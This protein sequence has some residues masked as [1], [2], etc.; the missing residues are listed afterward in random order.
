MVQVYKQRAVNLCFVPHS[1]PPSLPLFFSQA[2]RPRWHRQALAMEHAEVAARPT[3]PWRVYVISATIVLSSNLLTSSYFLY[4]LV[5]SSPQHISSDNLISQIN[6]VGRFI[7]EC[8]QLSENA[9]HRHGNSVRMSFGLR[10]NSAVYSDLLQVPRRSLPAPD[11]IRSDSDQIGS[12][13]APGPDPGFQVALFT[14][15]PNRDRLT[16]QRQ[17]SVVSSDSDSIDG[18]E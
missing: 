6:R 12:D 16:E 17:I 1:P 8:I 4:C 18:E 11:P 3:Q 5:E 14:L 15:P 7:A 13:S 9:L 10:N 2:T